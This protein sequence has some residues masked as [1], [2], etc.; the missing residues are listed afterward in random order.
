VGNLTIS[1]NGTPFAQLIAMNKTLGIVLVVFGL[2]VLV[3]GGFSFK[4]REK[5]LDI[6]PI[7]ATREK[8]HHVPIA[9]VAGAVAVA[10]GIGLL[11]LR[12]A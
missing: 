1:R 4:T 3:W 9:P 12:R 7:E 11:I 10:A 8:T 5:V 2:L 6:G